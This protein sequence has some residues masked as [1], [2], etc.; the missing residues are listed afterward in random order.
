MT[1]YLLCVSLLLSLMTPLAFGQRLLAAATPSF[2]DLF[3]TY[4]LDAGEEPA[5]IKSGILA[6]EDELDLDHL[7]GNTLGSD[8][9]S[10]PADRRL[11]AEDLPGL[12]PQHTYTRLN[13]AD[14]IFNRRGPATVVI[15]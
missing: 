2:R 15:M 3:Y 8:A 5:N 1:K 6:A 4:A 9:L 7:L 10:V 12:L 11:V 13:H 14:D